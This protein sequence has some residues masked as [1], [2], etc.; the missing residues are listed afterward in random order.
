MTA[1]PAQEPLADRKSI[2]F[3]QD[4]MTNDFRRAQVFEVRDAL[5]QYPNINFRY[6]D[7]RGQTS[8]LIHQIEQLIKQGIDLLIVGTNILKPGVIFLKIFEHKV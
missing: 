4:T 5:K 7:A 8:L 6:T 3:P 1:C 2:V